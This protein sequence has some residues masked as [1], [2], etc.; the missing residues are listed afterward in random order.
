MDDSSCSRDPIRK[1]LRPLSALTLVR[2]PDYDPSTDST[3]ARQNL[4]DE[5]RFTVD[6]NPED[7]LDKVGAGDL[8][9]EI[10]VVPAQTLER[11]ARSPV[12]RKSLRQNESDAIFYITMNLT[13]PPFD[14]VHVRRAMNWIVDK[15]ALQQYWGGPIV[16]SVANHIIPDE[17]FGGELTGYRP[18]GTPGNHGSLARAR[19]AMKGSRY[20]T[21][22]DGT[23]SAALCRHVLLLSDSTSVDVRILSDTRGRRRKDRNHIHRAHGGGSLPDPR[24]DCAKHPDRRLPGLVEGLSGRIDV[25]DPTRQSQHPS[26]GEHQLLTRRHH[27]DRREGRRRDR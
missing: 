18:Y 22:G 16:G 26:D 7:I 1:R 23:C 20:D 15:A 6:S 5:F 27:P 25:P 12:L 21:R 2:N 19:E 24:V 3:A 4:P 14:D 17:I 9:D 10:A 11:Y 13:Q 8:D